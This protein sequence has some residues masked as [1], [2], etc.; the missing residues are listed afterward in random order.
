MTVEAS[1]PA[2]AP[3]DG[4]K[5]HSAGGRGIAGQA[6]LPVGAARPVS[7]RFLFAAYPELMGRVLSIVTR[8][9]STH[10]AHQAGLTK[11]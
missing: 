6:D 7:P 9:I 3:A 11:S 2:A 1:A 8:T 10:P 4:G 5:R